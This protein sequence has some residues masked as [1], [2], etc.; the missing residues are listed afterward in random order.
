MYYAYGIIGVV[1]KINNTIKKI[2]K[3][4]NLKF[5]FILFAIAIFISAPF[6]HA[7][8]LQEKIDSLKNQNSTYQSSLSQ[9][10][11]Q[12]RS[13]QDAINILQ[14]QIN[15]LQNA[16][17]INNDHITS[18]EAQIT[19]AE[20]DLKYQKT[21]L[22]SDVKAIYVSGSV[23]TTEMLA[24]SKNLSVFVDQ[25]TYQKAVEGKIQKT[26]NAI[27]ALE[28]QL[29]LQKNQVQETI[30]IQKSQNQKIASD[31]SQQQSLLGYNQQQ[32]SQFN[33]QIQTNQQQITALQ[34]EQ[35]AAN[36]KL[37]ATGQVVSSGT[38][39]G[40]YPVTAVGSYGNWGCS[41]PKDNT[42]DNWG[43]YN[44]ECVSYTAWMV[45]KTFGYMPYWGGIGN[46]N[47]WPGDA[48][49]AN[50]PT[51]TTP[52]VNS[53]AIFM[54]NSNDPYG[55]AMWVKSVNNDGTI[56]VDQYNLLYDGNFYETTIPNSGLIY[57]Y[58]GS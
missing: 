6:A 10:Q 34:A 41:Y 18:L 37:L 29:N 22:A 31:Q 21:V 1:M 26:L 14:N 39:G 36:K 38:C 19:K 5:V 43:M 9:L 15:S 23:S 50:I 55:H 4:N 7:D 46:A 8:T 11:G 13:Y 44:R 56:T 25:V 52:K 53:V 24:S 3:I 16:I 45:Y 17:N 49:S 48:Q 20:D 27:S 2:V 35:L 47:Q 57:I 40:S 33:S 58:F 54:G 12:A 32:Q 28:I 42:I 51:G 30:L